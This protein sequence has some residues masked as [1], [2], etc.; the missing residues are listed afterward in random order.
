MTFQIQDLITLIPEVW[1]ILDEASDSI[2]FSPLLPSLLE[3][4]P[5]PLFP[6]SVEK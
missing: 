3:L 2:F 5:N 4:S 1:L 6:K